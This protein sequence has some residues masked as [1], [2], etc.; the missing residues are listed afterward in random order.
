M[1]K[2]KFLS[3]ES[4]FTRIT[5]PL[6]R[7]LFPVIFSM[8][9]IGCLP[10]AA[11]ASLVDLFGITGSDGSDGVFS[12][13][14]DL[15]VDFDAEH[16]FQF[17]SIMIGSDAT[18]RYNR[19]DA[20][21][22]VLLLSQGDILIDGT[23]QV[24]AIG[25]TGGPGGGNAGDLNPNLPAGGTIII[26]TGTGGSVTLPSAGDITL[27]STGNIAIGTGDK[28][29][30]L[31]PVDV[32][33]PAVYGGYGGIN[34]GGG[35]ALLLHSL[36]GNIIIGGRIFATGGIAVGET[37]GGGDGGLIELWA[38]GSDPDSGEIRLL[39]GGYLSAAGALGGEGGTVALN[40]G[41]IVLEEGSAITVA[42]VPIPPSLWLMGTGILGLLA[43]RKRAGLD[44]G[45]SGTGNRE[46]E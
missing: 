27:G 15:V 33:T 18:V 20:N 43:C 35:G 7:I 40:A 16:V 37:D 4:V 6:K 1:L 22:P 14:D 21:T 8:A 31:E 3:P 36:Y 13:S 30:A 44:D 25:S 41:N 28:P 17:S 12:I 11:F 38:L 26:D 46:V 2:S 45:P 29:A 39:S 10:E 34:G 23:L 9:V 19:N 5:V 42:P 24:S 32:S